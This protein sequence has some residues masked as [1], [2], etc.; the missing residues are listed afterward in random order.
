MRELRWDGE[1]GRIQVRF[2]YD[3]K[4]VERVRNLTGRRWHPEE[5]YW[6]IPR[7]TLHEAAG[8]LFPLGFEPDPGVREL[9]EGGEEVA[10][11]ITGEVREPGPARGSRSTPAP[12]Q[13]APRTGSSEAEAWSVSALNERVR[14]IFRREFKGTLWVVGEVVGYD[15]NATRQHA[16][17]QLADK[18]EGAESPQ[19]IVSA[20]LFAGTRRSVDETLARAAG[21]LALQDGMKVR[22]EVKVDLY[23]KNGSYQLVVQSVDPTFTLGEIA[24][25]QERILEEVRRAGVA[26]RN[27]ALPFPTPALRIGL[28]TSPDSDAYNDFVS[29]LGRSGFAFRL[30]L[31]GVRV[32]GEGLE[33]DVLTALDHFARRSEE[34][35]LLVVT[36]G[37]GSRTDLMGFDSLALALAVAR[38]PLKVVVGIGHQRDRSVLDAIAH[39]EKT[40][41]AAAALLVALARDAEEFLRARARDLSRI[42]GAAVQGE[43]TRVR[44]WQERL[45]DR[46]RMRTARA[47]DRLRVA[48]VGL[49]RGVR[50]ALRQ[51]R[52][53]LQRDGVHLSAGISARFATAREKA[54]RQRQEL[55]RG[56]TRSLVR[57]RER[58]GESS[59]QLPRRSARALRDS[60]TR[61]A[62]LEERV[63]SRD[64][65]RVLA[66]GYAWLQRPDGGTI[67][68]TGEVSPG[69]LLRARLRDGTLEARV[70]ST[71]PASE[72]EGS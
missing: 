36:R 54:D 60:T 62:A 4:L 17:F 22:F 3:K 59:L 10:S 68:S 30:S 23:P 2:S 20:V 40:P 50:G 46:A 48:S 58:L 28:I 14:S 18:A 8:A 53:R 61:L 5:R 13:P 41:T 1:S 27:L 55:R 37:G 71:A 12:L 35:D 67:T 24:Q 26:E 64:P 11:E 32:Q 39:S 69:D 25:R 47:R 65:R 52:S 72:E 43:R 51:A 44:S 57:A 29:E 9:L 66:R 7:E 56:A 16:Y 42:I 15:R 31:F 45:R 38:H 70:E 34:F 19:A 49:P 33:G 21:G 6:S 63:L